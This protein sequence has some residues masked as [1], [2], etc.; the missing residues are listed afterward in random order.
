VKAEDIKAEYVN[1]VLKVFLPK[2]E[3]V[4]PASTTIKIN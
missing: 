4:K 3:P 2:A 1:G